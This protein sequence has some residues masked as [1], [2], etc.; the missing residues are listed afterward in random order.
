MERLYITSTRD[1]LILV[2]IIDKENR[3]LFERNE[4]LKRECS[5][6]QDIIKLMVESI[7]ELDL[8]NNYFRQMIEKL[9]FQ[10]TKQ[11]FALEEK[12]TG[13]K[14]KRSIFFEYQEISSPSVVSKKDFALQSS[15]SLSRNSSSYQTSKDRLTFVNHDEKEIANWI[16]DY[17]SSKVRKK[18]KYVRRLEKLHS[19]H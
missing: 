13:L 3:E 8:E 15:L 19:I 11:V 5:N 14:S 17:H 7:H 18:R 16:Q 1:L 12:E 2:E 9:I 10:Q 6:Q 4:T